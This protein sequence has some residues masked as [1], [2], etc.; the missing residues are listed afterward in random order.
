[1][2]GSSFGRPKPLGDYGVTVH[3]S[4]GAIPTVHSKL[5][6]LWWFVLFPGLVPVHLNHHIMLCGCL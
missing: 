6:R 1:M 4:Y 2:F 3:N 5:D